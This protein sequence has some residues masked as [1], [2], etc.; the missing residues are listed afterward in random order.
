MHAVENWSLLKTC[1][2]S[3]IYEKV[4]VDQNA[5]FP[6]KTEKIRRLNANF[7]VAF[8]HRM[9][10]L[11]WL[12]ICSLLRVPKT[13][14]VTLADLSKA[15]HSKSS[16]Y[17]RKGTVGGFPYKYIYLYGSP[18]TVPFLFKTFQKNIFYLRNTKRLR[19]LSKREKKQ[20]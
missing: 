15:L 1:P 11:L 5:I 14:L 16:K 3:K 2:L 13:I 10:K 19:N 8:Q 17:K 12:S 4:N 6:I 20:Y 18:P 9:P 7:G